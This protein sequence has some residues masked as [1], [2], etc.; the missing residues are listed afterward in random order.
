M[1]KRSRP[2]PPAGRPR[3]P[4]RSSGS[5]YAGYVEHPRFGRSPRRTGLD[6]A[7]TPDGTVYC[8]WHSPAGVRVPNTAIAA[9]VARQKPAT[10]PVTHYY[11]AKRVCRK[12][13]RPFLFF[14]EEQKHWYEELGFPLEADCLECPPCRKDAQKLRA[15]HRQYDALLARADRSEADTLELV[16]CALQLLESSVF[17]PKALPRLRA[18]LRPLLADPSGPRHAEAT[19]L[20]SRIAGIAA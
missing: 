4:A 9:D 12:C 11:D 1:A 7:N 8:H 16:R 14:A 17:T 6:V 15:L 2:S 20:L 5:E 3:L 10:I 13:G 19:A 18:L